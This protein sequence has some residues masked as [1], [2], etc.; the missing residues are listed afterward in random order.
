MI[1]SSP[2]GQQVLVNDHAMFTMGLFGV[3]LYDPADR[4]AGVPNMPLTLTL[5]S[6]IDDCRDMIDSFA[7]RI[8]H[9]IVHLHNWFHQYRALMIDFTV[10]CRAY[11]IDQTSLSRPNATIGN[12]VRG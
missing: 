10:V 12:W 11:K 5:L 3:L 7:P 1:T 6:S 9:Q 8:D 4:V 2:N